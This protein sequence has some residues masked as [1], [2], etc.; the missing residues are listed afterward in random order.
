MS[1]KIEEQRS[2]ILDIVPKLPGRNFRLS[3]NSIK[4]NM[5]RLYFIIIVIILCFTAVPVAIAS[6]IIRHYD[7]HHNITGYTVID[8]DRQTHY[9]SSWNRTGHTIS[10]ETKD[11]HYDIKQ[12]RIGHTEWD[13][14]DT[15]SHYDKDHNRTGYSKKYKD[16]E[17][18]FDKSWNRKGYKK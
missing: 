5:N 16:K 13:N 1:L 18:M 4:A 15:G 3:P 17:T 10:E 2:F 6:D 14:D 8:G 11:T 9:D 12:N 7:E